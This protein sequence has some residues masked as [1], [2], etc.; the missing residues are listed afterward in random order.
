MEYAKMMRPSPRKVLCVVMYFASAAFICLITRE[1]YLHFDYE[2]VVFPVAK[3]L[4]CN[5]TRSIHRNGPGGS[6]PPGTESKTE[7]SD[8][9]I[10]VKTTR[11]YHSSR[12]Q[13]IL[14]TWYSLAPEEIYFFTDVDDSELQEKT[15][16]HMVNTGCG[17][18]YAML[19]LCCKLSIIISMFHET[20]KRCKWTER[21][22]H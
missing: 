8:V 10:G 5:H 22:C 12:L 2:R 21:V 6:R 14:D 4:V 20:S 3:P 9:F 16:G 1:F 17:Q 18:G 13:L 7:I 19:T 15:N 11:K